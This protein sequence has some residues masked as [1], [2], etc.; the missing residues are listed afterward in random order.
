MPSAA[1]SG[2]REA[3]AR[4]SCTPCAAWPPPP[5]PEAST[6]RARPA[7]NSTAPEASLIDRQ[8]PGLGD[9]DALL[10]VAVHRRGALGGTGHAPACLHLLPRRLAPGPRLPGQ[11][12]LTAAGPKRWRLPA[13]SRSLRPAA[14]QGPWGRI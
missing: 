3:A 5:H 8:N 14:S 9:T 13:S 7:C 10:L 1:P 4:R 12:L 11:G 2:G 6:P